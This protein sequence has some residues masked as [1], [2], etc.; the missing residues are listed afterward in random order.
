MELRDKQKVV[1]MIGAADEAF[2]KLEQGVNAI[3]AQG[4]S[5]QKDDLKLLRSIERAIDLLKSN[6]F[7]GDP[8]AQRLW[9]RE[10]ND[11]PNLFRLELSQFWRLLYYVTGDEV[12]VISVIFEIVD[13]DKYN[14]IF[15]Y[16]KK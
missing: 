15:D 12:R 3:E 4:K 14:K 2:T 8:V 5:P 16:K 1:K 13:H 9:P 11:L 7:T 10:F 6:P